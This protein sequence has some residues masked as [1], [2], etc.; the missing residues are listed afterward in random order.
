M[1]IFWKEF[2]SCSSNI[3][4]QLISKL[5]NSQYYLGYVSFLLNCAIS[6]AQEFCHK[7][8]LKRLLPLHLTHVAKR[9]LLAITVDEAQ[10]LG[11]A[12][13][14]ILRNSNVAN[15]YLKSEHILSWPSFLRMFA[16]WGKN[17][18]ITHPVITC[19]ER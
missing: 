15:I 14:A 13:Y 7:T 1:L 10:T 16:H 12:K 17:V 5:K 19:I 4:F 8:I 18:T 3:F 2:A 11:Q 9:T 6:K